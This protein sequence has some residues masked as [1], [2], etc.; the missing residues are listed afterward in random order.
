VAGRTDVESTL[1]PGLRATVRRGEQQ[2]IPLTS[3][4]GNPTGESVAPGDKVVV[5]ETV[6]KGLVAVDPHNRR[7]GRPVDH[8]VGYAPRA[9]FALPAPDGLLGSVRFP[10]SHKTSW[11]RLREVNVA[12]LRAP[13]QRL[14]G[15]CSLLAAVRAAQAAAPDRIYDMVTLID[16]QCATGP[17][18]AKVR[19]FSKDRHGRF[20][21]EEVTVTTRRL[22]AQIPCLPHMMRPRFGA[23]VEGQVAEIGWPLLGRPRHELGWM[24][25]EKARAKTMADGTWNALANEGQGVVE[26]FEWLLG[27]RTETISLPKDRPLTDLYEEIRAA[28]ARGEPVVVVAGNDKYCHAYP[29]LR[30][31]GG[32][33]AV[34]GTGHWYKSRKS[35]SREV[36]AKLRL[37]GKRDFFGPPVGIVNGMLI[38]GITIAR[39]EYLTAPPIIHAS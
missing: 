1:E 24:L 20:Q 11:T 9:A 37:D 36:I 34:L 35:P 5:F 28:Y 12:M 17:Q 30:I 6:Q 3:P 39:R 32:G 13:R 21:P 15:D 29:L 16:R 14:S 7:W 2:P 27:W 8:V 23:T 22:R 18:R 4:S 26:T 33:R 31:S 25:I 10:V 38:L 19:Y